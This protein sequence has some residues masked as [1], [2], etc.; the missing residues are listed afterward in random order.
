MKTVLLLPI[1]LLSIPS[2]S[3]KS[4]RLLEVELKNQFEKIRSLDENPT[5]NDTINTYD[6][7][8]RVNDFI[9]GQI[10]K[11]GNNNAALLNYT[12]TSLNQYIDVATS[13][14]KSFRVYSWD[15][16]TGGSMHFYY[17]VAQYL[18]N[19][20]KVYTQSLVDNSE[21]D[22]GLWYSKIYTFNN[23]GK[24]YYFCI[25]HG[26]YSSMEL[27]QEV[28]IY[29]I[30]GTF[31]VNAQIIRTQTRITNSIHVSYHL[32]TVDDK[33][34]QS[35]VFDETRNEL[36]IPLVDAKGKMSDKNII[37]KFNGTHFERAGIR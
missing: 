21:G 31:L 15:T 25:G 32:P 29:T 35:I 36:T 9:L 33:N 10:V 17:A 34:D 18:G 4:P 12:F 3:Q 11:Q 16:Y 37:Y 26:K 27:A 22:P 14:E 30:K 7:M 5:I 8:Q 23:K 28:T 19:D 2:F 24:K 20:N 1:L 13:K 6:S